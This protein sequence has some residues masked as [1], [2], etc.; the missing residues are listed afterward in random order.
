M[1]LYLQLW[2]EPTVWSDRK[3]EQ[4]TVLLCQ[5][6][7]ESTAET[8]CIGRTHSHTG[9]INFHFPRCQER[10]VWAQCAKKWRLKKFCCPRQICGSWVEVRHW[11]KRRVCVSQKCVHT[12]K[13]LS[14]LFCWNRRNR[15]MLD[16]SERYTNR[17]GNKGDVPSTQACTE[18]HQ[19]WRMAILCHWNKGGN[20]S[21]TAMTTPGNW[22]N[23][24]RWVVLLGVIPSQLQQYL[25]Q[26]GPS[27]IEQQRGI[28]SLF[29][30]TLFD[31]RQSSFK[32]WPGETD[33]TDTGLKPLTDLF[34]LSRKQD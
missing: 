20:V 15:A 5:P 12:E 9:Y 10:C 28:L 30:C 32:N 31:K 26:N 16:F 6:S 3:N 1:K 8:R 25:M 33:V 34:S 17:L 4:A 2:C 14:P 7:F 13:L 11:K 29:H 27:K 19:S 24:T 22:R 23:S 21:E 18:D